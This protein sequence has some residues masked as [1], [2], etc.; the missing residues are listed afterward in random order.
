MPRFTKSKASLWF[1]SVLLVRYLTTREYLL[2][3]LK[4]KGFVLAMSAI[5]RL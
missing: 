4:N 2:S 1:F 5:S 3:S